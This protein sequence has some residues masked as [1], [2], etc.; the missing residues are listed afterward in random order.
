MRGRRTGRG[1]LRVGGSAL[2]AALA[3]SVV[4][5]CGAG[6]AG[7]SAAA[8][9]QVGSAEVAATQAAP[10]RAAAPDA[11]AGSGSAG[12]AG[13]GEAGSAAQ[14]P[15]TGQVGGTSVI[16]V[17]DLT[18]RLEAPPVPTTDDATADREANA[19]VRSELVAATAGTIRGIATTAGGFVA[20]ANGGGSAL[21]VTLRVPADQYD[22]V[23]DRIA[24]LGPVTARTE[25]SQD[26]TA[27]VIDVNSRVASL[28]AS[29]ERV[30]ALL[31]QATNIA[32]VIA[33]ESELATREADLESLQQQQA[34]LQGQVAMSTVTVGLNAVTQSAVGQTE[35]LPDNGFVAGLKAGWANLLQ[36]LTW[37]G[38]LLGGLLPWLPLIA[39]VAGV[40]WWAG[41]RLRRHRRPGSDGTVP[42]PAGGRGHEPGTGPDRGPDGG[43]DHEPDPDPTGTSPSQPA[44]VG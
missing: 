4:A 37:L 41:R 44:G 21:T 1:V 29:V 2:L 28:T 18:V 34:A 11:S 7:S 31:G 8:V 43:P 9:D 3:M 23:L 32:D 22:A 38:A 10:E 24:G 19:K 42:P 13:G 26:V 27:Q 17:A 6:S 33:I 20:A 25:S 14:L 36:F 35:P 30:R 40:L 5:A 15:L 39:L 12:S 16:K